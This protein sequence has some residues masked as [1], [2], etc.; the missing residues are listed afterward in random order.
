LRRAVFV[1]LLL[2]LTAGMGEGHRMFLGHRMSLEIFAFYDDGEP[3]RNADISIYRLN[4]TTED[5]D[6]YEAG[7]TDAQGI[8]KVTLPGKGTGEWR[9]AISGAGHS[10]EGYFTVSAERPPSPEAKALALALLPGLLIT[11][12]VRKR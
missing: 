8:Y 2:L 4:G 1:A 3:A 10:E 5:Y 11:W 6:L 12:R 7:V 9:Y